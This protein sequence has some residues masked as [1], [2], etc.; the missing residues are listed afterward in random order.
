MS[1]EE[2]LLAL[3]QAN[4][5]LPVYKLVVYVYIH[6]ADLPY[7]LLVIDCMGFYVDIGALGTVL[8]MTML[9]KR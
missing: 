4:I 8:Q 9:H 1:C 5:P 2:T 7:R 3:T 6:F